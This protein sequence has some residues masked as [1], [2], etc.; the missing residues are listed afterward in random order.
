MVNELINIINGINPK[1]YVTYE[2]ASMMNVKADLIPHQDGEYYQIPEDVS[3]NPILEYIVDNNLEY[4]NGAGTIINPGE[5]LQ[6]FCYIEEFRQGKYNKA[7]HGWFSKST[8]VQ[9][10]FCKIGQFHS[11]A[12]KRELL[13]SDIEQEI[14]LPF[15]KQ[16]NG[17]GLFKTIDTFE[18]FTPPPRFDMN[19]VSIMLQF[20]LDEV[21]C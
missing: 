15:I 21:S 14:V 5:R 9:L 11:D 8:K 12:L 7:L 2:E 18:F 17:T 3:G 4:I 6:G 20:N 13:R 10:W 1:Y 19:E 16:V